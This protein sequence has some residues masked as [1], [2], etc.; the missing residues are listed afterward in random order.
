MSE[1][2]IQFKV[3]PVLKLVMVAAIFVALV[4]SWF[5]IRWYLGNTI[6]E[7]L[8][9]DQRQLET[10][11]LAVRMAPHDPLTHWRL[12]KLIATELHSNQI[13][14][15][16]AEYEQATS[17]APNDYRFW[18][19]LG[20]ALEQSGDSANAEKALRTA[21]KLA[22]AYAYPHWHLGNLLLRNGQYAEAFTELRRAGE[23]NELLQP[24]LFNLAWQ[25]NRDDFESLKASVGNASATR[26][27]FS[28]YLAAR[29]KFDDALRLWNSLSETEKKQYRA[30]ADSMIESLI[31][32]KRFHL[33]MAVWN[34]I[35][36]SPSVRAQLG[37]FT[38]P[39]FENGVVNAPGVIFGW[40]LP[41][42]ALVLVNVDPT[43]GRDVDGKS[44]K[45]AF[46]V[47]EKLDAINVTQLIP[48]EPN[49][50]YDFECYFKTEKLISAATP[51]LSFTDAADGASIVTSPALPSDDHNW[52]S[53]TLSFKTGPKT[54][55]VKFS[56]DRSRC[57]ADSP[58]CPI[59]GTVWYDDFNLKARK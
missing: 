47:R 44:L 48:V 5:V 2:V 41:S 52:E 10:A 34:D 29:G 12:G 1:E 42:I 43:V 3:T 4:A 36:P 19:D 18:M 51:V 37:Q 20:G 57:D 45:L 30:A 6:A 23:A 16:V 54:E 25:V 39:G 28:Q 13:T 59:Y 32:E 8:V 21:V 50:Q 26:A 9:P 38:D 35:A 11:E 58:V 22:P 56:I 27:Q 17:L 24:Q 7:N 46:Q 15:V 53:I 31:K 33:A 14:R 49:T 55:A 40:R